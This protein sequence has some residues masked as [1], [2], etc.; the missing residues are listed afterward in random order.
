MDAILEQRPA[1]A[2][3]CT[4][5]WAV[6]PIPFSQMVRCVCE[7]SISNAVSAVEWF[8]GIIA[9][10]TFHLIAA[11]VA[12]IVVIFCADMK[13]FGC[14]KVRIIVIGVIS[15]NTNDSMHRYAFALF[16]IVH[17]HTDTYNCT[18]SSI[19]A[20]D[21]IPYNIEYF[22]QILW[23]FFI[24]VFDFMCELEKV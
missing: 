8:S 17:T 14:T 3:Q 20:I 11:P 9:E 18:Q 10:R 16:I 19:S 13:I 12:S 21:L 23:K 1:Y 6:S 4:A 7:I 24:F 5:T 2:T 15:H 22:E